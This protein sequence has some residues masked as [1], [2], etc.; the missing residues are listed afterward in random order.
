[1]ATKV[2]PHIGSSLEEFLEE[3]GLRAEVEAR[4]VKRV[5]V[6]QLQQAM[7]KQGLSKAALARAMGTSRAAVHRLLDPE[8]DSVTLHTLERAAAAV[9][10]RLRIELEELP[11]TRS[12]SEKVR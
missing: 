7:A 1:M 11:P 12:E 10:K 6:W 2:H 4:A 5:L 9:G 8:N 3:E